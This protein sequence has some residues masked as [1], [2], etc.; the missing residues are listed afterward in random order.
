MS[1]TAND[2]QP[3]LL[4]IFN[5]LSSATLWIF[6]GL[7]PWIF[8]SI[9]LHRYLKFGS[10]CL[11][12]VLSCTLVPLG[13]GVSRDGFGPALASAMEP[14]TGVEK[15]RAAQ[16]AGGLLIPTR[17]TRKETLESR[18]KLLDDFRSWLWECHQVQ[19]SVLLT[20]KPPDPELVCYWLVAYGQAMHIAGKAYGRYAETINA[21][22]S[23]RPAI[24]KQLAPAWD[25]AFS[26]LEDEPYQHHPALPLAVLLGMLTAALLWG[27]PV[28]AAI[29]S[30]TWAG[31]L[32]VGESLMSTRADLILPQD[33]SPGT[34]FALL[35]IRKPKTRGRAAKHQA[36]KIDAPDVIELLSAV[37]GALP[38]DARLW[39]FSAATLRKRF[40]S[41]LSCLK[42]PTKRVNGINP[43]TLGSLRPGGATHLLLETENS[44]HVRRRGRWVTMK[45]CE[46]YLQEVLYTTYTQKLNSDTRNRIQELASAYPETLQTA[47]NFIASGI[48]AR[49][50]YTLF[51]ARDRQEHGNVGKDGMN[52]AAPT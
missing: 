10:L 40:N 27:W 43:F 1:R 20:A 18:K 50:W 8:A 34:E 30:M 29:L 52:L 24:R 35:R 49:A 19:L 32:R 17:V 37:F 6:S 45:V 48:P 25:L 4:W 9:L 39:P 44:E 22:S 33:A 28:E 38:E 11:V 12:L 23:A 5:G 31:I 41:L 21:I 15:A 3:T 51:Q 36:A 42:L 14:A 16:R 7:A 2:Q 46:V 47:L 26:W 13:V